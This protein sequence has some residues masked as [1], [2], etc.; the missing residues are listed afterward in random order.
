V[1]PEWGPA[2]QFYPGDFLSDE[3]S[4]L[5]NNAA[6][7]VY[8]R[9]LCYAWNEGSIPENVALLARLVREDLATFTPLWEDVKV[10][11]VASNEPGRLIN[12][13]MESI[14]AEQIAYRKRQ[15][16]KG[17]ASAEKRS[18]HGSTPVQRR[19]NRGS[20]PVQ[21]RQPQP[22]GN[23]SPSPSSIDLLRRSFGEAAEEV[24]ALVDCRRAQN[25]SGRLAESVIASLIGGLKSTLEAVAGDMPAFRAGLQ[26]ALA[27]EAPNANYVKKAAL[28]AKDRLSNVTRLL[29]RPIQ[30]RNNYDNDAAYRETRRSEDV[31]V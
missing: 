9:L 11:F 23:P 22:E 4:A 6:T 27:A 10:C 20:T 19:F 15:S 8:I 18:N 25:S 17:K 3:R 24:A 14:R 26:A 5:M 1:K 13:R 12:E 31:P 7:G 29:P 2:F 21:P 16:T 30:R 28:S